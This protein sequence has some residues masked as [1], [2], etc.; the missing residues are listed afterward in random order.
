M[1]LGTHCVLMRKERAR[2]EKILK[3]KVLHCSPGN[4]FSLSPEVLG[5]ATTH[6]MQKLL[7]L[8]W[9]LENVSMIDSDKDTRYFFSKECDNDECLN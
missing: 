8:G 7:N 9:I 2:D 1:C 4:L 3:H 6:Q 5:L